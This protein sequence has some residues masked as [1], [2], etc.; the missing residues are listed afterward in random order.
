M[1]GLEELIRALG[2]AGWGL[3]AVGF[4][5][6]GMGALAQGRPRS[7]RLT[8]PAAVDG[9][10]ERLAHSAVYTPPPHRRNYATNRRRR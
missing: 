10:P 8:V 4:L 2:T 1:G 9:P 5:V 7:R 3:V 6:V